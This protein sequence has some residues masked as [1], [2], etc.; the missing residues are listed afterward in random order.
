M[1]DTSPPSSSASSPA[2]GSAPKNQLDRDLRGYLETN[3]DILTVVRKPVEIDDI[4][5]LTAQSHGPI[6]FENIVGKP[7]YRLCDMLVRH[8]WSQAR[9]LGVAPKDFL[10]TLGQRLRK[11][12]RGYTFVD[13][14]P[15]KEV[16]LT[17]KD[18]DWTEMPI[19]FHTDA[20]EFP[21][22]TAMNILKDPETGFYNTCNAGTT[23]AGPAEGLVSYVTPHAY[24]VMGKWRARGETQVPVAF[25]WGVPPAYE[26][27]ANFS[28][29]HMDLW[30]ELEMVGT[31]M[32]QDVEMVKCETIDMYVPAHAEIVA[33][34]VLDISE[35]FPFGTSVSPSMYYMPKEQKLPKVTITAI[36]RRADRPIYRNHQTVP[37]TDHQPLPRLCH[38]AVLYNRLTEMG[39]KVH[40]IRF[41]TWGGALSCIIQ[42]EYPRDGFVNDAL[43]QCMG[44]PWLNTKMVVAVGPETD[45]ESAEQVY[46]AI[47]SRVDPARDVIIV[48]NTRGSL[49]DPSGAPIEGDPPWRTVGKIGIDATVKPRNDVKRED[50]AWPR[51]WG[52]V[53]LKDYLD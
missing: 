20:E 52:K 9:A 45:I 13:T 34:G 23:P 22:I 49:F 21:Y 26:I 11:A 44:A 31:I 37:D 25:V 2:A 43:L 19:P 40:D 47:A 36:T 33:E 15:V 48:P 32:D 14:G 41:P 3:A 39:L 16:V 4:G 1:N 53:R 10:P 30:G 35:L 8:R 51:N 28:G 18:I 27:M 24:A 17:G 12:P 42:V 38:E 46:H 29:L 6:L 5:A 7:G 50:R